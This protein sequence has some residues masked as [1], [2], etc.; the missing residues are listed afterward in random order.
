MSGGKAKTAPPPKEC[1]DWKGNQWTPDSKEKAAHPN[2]RFTAPMTNNPAAGPGGQR[3]QRRADQRHHLRRPAQRHHAAGLPGLQLDSRR[4]HRRDDG[5]GNDRRRR[6][7]SR[8]GAPRSRWP[9]CRSAATTWAIISGTGST[10]ARPSSTRRA[11]F[12]STGSARTARAN[13]S[14]P[15]SARTCACSNGSSTAATAAPTREE[16]PLG[17]VPGPH[18]F[19]LTGLNRL[20]PGQAG[21]GPGD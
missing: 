2:S 19:D 6:R 5:L 1:L 17:W 13:S 18:D 21:R 8:P 12:T 10:C 3:S 15:A 9:C 14:G 4:L 20:R 7:R 16:T 11:S